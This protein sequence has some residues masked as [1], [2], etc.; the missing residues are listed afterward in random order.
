MIVLILLVFLVLL[1]FWSIKPR[2]IRKKEIW[3]QLEKVEYAHRGFFDNTKEYPENS[4]P[5]FQRAV[6]AGFGIE[7]D[8]QMTTD[9][10][11][12][13]FHDGTLKRMCHVDKMLSEMSFEE[14]QQYTLKKSQEKIPTFEQ[15]LKIVDGKVPLIVEIK[16]EGKPIETVKKACEML[17]GYKGSYVMESFH[18]GV[19]YWLKKNRKDILRGQLSEDYSR[20]DTFNFIEKFILTNCMLNGITKPDFVAYDVRCRHFT[21]FQMM[22]KL[23]KFE[24]VCWTIK[25][26]YQL[27]MAHEQFDLCIFDSF[28]PRKDSI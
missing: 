27:E 10:I 21:I 3:E 2:S 8:V 1:F 23:F 20:Y 13:I 4:L 7:L 22:C 5:A 15:V 12:V 28:D 24:K 18:P 14:C 25:D 26:S 6:E 11:L 17:D 9:G 16:S 19:V